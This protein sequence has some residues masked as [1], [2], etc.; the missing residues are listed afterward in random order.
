LR[1]SAGSAL[2]I[3]AVFGAFFLLSELV[4]GG[5]AALV[6]PPAGYVLRDLV[7]A[8]R[9]ARWQK[10]HDHVLAWVGSGDEVESRILL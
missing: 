6:G 2:F 3:V 9:V 5:G 7:M 1:R 4:P 8:I 10:R